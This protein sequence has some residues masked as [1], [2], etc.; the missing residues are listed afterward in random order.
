M[1]T[2]PMMQNTRMTPGSSWAKLRLARWLMVAS[3]RAMREWSKAAIA[4]VQSC[5]RNGNALAGSS[6]VVY[7]MAEDI[8]LVLVD[9]VLARPGVVV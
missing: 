5:L 7:P 1:A 2:A 9:L 8:M 3:L 4:I 6:S